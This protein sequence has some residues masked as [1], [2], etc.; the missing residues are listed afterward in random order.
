MEKKKL[1]N[2]PAIRRFPSYLH[3]LKRLE[4]SGNEFVS[5][6]ELIERLDFEAVLIRKDLSGLGL[7]GIPRK[8]YPLKELIAAIE[9]YLGWNKTDEAFLVGAGALGQALL[10]Y[11]LFDEK[12]LQIV[13]AFDH[14]PQKV[15]VEIHGKPVF[16]VAKLSN[17]AHRM[18]IRVAILCVPWQDAQ[19]I[20]DL[21]VES[22]IKAIWNFS[23]QELSAPEDVVCHNENL[24]SSLAVFS[25][26]MKKQLN[27]N[28]EDETQN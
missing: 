22:G 12:G 11:S 14:D 2:L 8:G 7:K 20:A 18:G 1:L 6:M 21:L 13:A 27:G 10:G 23:A 28:D 4:K 19:K 24:V 25:V 15:G 9:D 5:T 26:K 3:I 16:P 17:L